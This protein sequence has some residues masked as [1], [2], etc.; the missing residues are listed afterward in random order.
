[1]QL[2]LKKKYPAMK[3][4]R[5][6]Q[7]RVTDEPMLIMTTMTIKDVFFKTFLTRQT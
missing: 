6:L 2:D 1:M 5:R 7:V 4:T 3:P